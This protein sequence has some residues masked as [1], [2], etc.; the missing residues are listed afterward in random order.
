M[1][2]EI[3]DAAAPVGQVDAPLART[4]RY[5]ALRRRPTRAETTRVQRDAALG[6]Y[7][8]RWREAVDGASPAPRTMALWVGGLFSGVVLVIAVVML[9]R[10]DVEGAL[11]GLAS[12]AVMFVVP[13]A[14]AYLVAALVR[15]RRWRRHAQVAGFAAE[16]GLELLLVTGP[17]ELPPLVRDGGRLRSVVHGDLVIG[18]VRG[19][20]LI[21]GT[22]TG[23]IVSGDTS[24]TRHLVWAALRLDPARP[25]RL[26]SQASVEKRLRERRRG[27]TVH[28]RY[29][30]WFTVGYEGRSSD[31]VMIETLL[32]TLDLALRE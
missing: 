18:S 1:T 6:R 30:E 4:L 27:A 16:N 13:G 11:I 17:A 9:V 31:P 24:E 14:I 28:V 8:S 7:G 10:G 3:E 5:G 2:E 21:T 19:R 12:A 15:R 26:S 29:D 22:R 32:G 25:A 23:E 20:T